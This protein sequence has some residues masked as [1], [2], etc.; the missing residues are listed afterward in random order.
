[1]ISLLVYLSESMEM[2]VFQ[3][4][5]CEK[6]V[7]WDKIIDILLLDEGQTKSVTDLVTQRY[8]PISIGRSI[9]PVP[10]KSVRYMEKHLRCIKIYMDD[11]QTYSC[12]GKFEDIMPY[13]S[14]SFWRSH[15]S[16]IVNLEKVVMLQRYHFLAKNGEQLPVSQKK[17]HDTR[18]YFNNY[19]KRRGENHYAIN[20]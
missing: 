13:L 19:L 8:L 9:V 6:L 15:K 12:Y 20:P 1:M 14:Q 10:L 17:F 5:L 4:R 7:E 11:G 16:Y 18:L 2:D 3:K